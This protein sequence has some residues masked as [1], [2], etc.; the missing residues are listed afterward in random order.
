MEQVAKAQDLLQ[1]RLLSDSDERT[2]E[3]WLHWPAWFS[4]WGIKG[5]A[6]V[7]GLAFN[8]TR[9]V[10]R[11]AAAGQGVAIGRSVLVERLLELGD[12]V[13]LFDEIL[14]AGNAYYS[15]C[16]ETRRDEPKIAAFLDWIKDA[17]AKTAN[18]EMF[19]AS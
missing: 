18:A 13:R 12:V 14:P 7:A 10:N 6:K 2:Q 5:E 15:V 8:D 4:H 16:Q 17:L 3:P 19:T 1:H 9:L 11:A